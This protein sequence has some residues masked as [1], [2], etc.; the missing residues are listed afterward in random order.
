MNVRLETAIAQL[1]TLAEPQQERLAELLVELM[2]HIQDS[3]DPRNEFSS[4]EL[5]ELQVI[6]TEPFLAAD[7]VRIEALFARHAL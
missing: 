1:G 7:Q 2:T 5:A 6:S 3:S 4:A